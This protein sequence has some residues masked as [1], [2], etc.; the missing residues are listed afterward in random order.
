MSLPR[1]QPT[2][3]H[4]S[5]RAAGTNERPRTAKSQRTRIRILQAA[6]DVFG[7]RGY[8]AASISDITRLANI[9]QGTFYL[10][11]PSK[12]GVFIE[13]FDQLGHDMRATLH[14]ATA[15]APSRLATERAGIK[16]FLGFA[17]D[18]PRLFRIA[19]EA[20][21]VV[22]DLWY[23]WYDR[24][25]EPYERGLRTAAKAGEIRA[26]DPKLLACALIGLSDFVGLQLV[27][28]QGI[29]EVPD[30]VLDTLVDFIAHGLLLDHT[31]T[32]KRALHV[33]SSEQVPWPK[34]DRG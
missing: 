28:R 20:E 29:R 32:Q 5:P 11:F 33:E 3:W 34:G 19:R 12:L 27:A 9:A 1:A 14:L 10:H 2:E 16:A 31:M 26:L 25:I 4:R 7:N 17:A 23:E 6:E 21:F 15:E 24:L 30:S 18:H 22:P 13:L 8:F